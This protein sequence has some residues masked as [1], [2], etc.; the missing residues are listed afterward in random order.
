MSNFYLQLAERVLRGAI[1]PLGAQDII[2][3]ANERGLIP[4]KYRTAKTPDRTVQARIA[5]S[6][7]QLGAKSPFYR[8]APGRFGLREKLGDFTYSQ[9]FKREYKAPIRRKQISNEDI[10]CIPRKRLNIDGQNGFFPYEEFFSSI[11]GNE[12]LQYLPRKRLEHDSTYKQVVTYIAVVKSHMVLCY[13]RGLYAAVQDELIGRKSIG[14]GGHVSELDRDLFSIDDLGILSNGRRE[15]WEE[16]ALANQAEWDTRKLEITGL[17]NDNSTAEG[18]KHIAVAML[19][20]CEEEDDPIKGELEIRNLH[21]LSSMERPNDLFKFE[22]WSQIYLEQL[23]RTRM[24]A[25]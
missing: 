12:Y 1:Q 25:Y 23:C 18:Q 16:L 11:A 4:I 3:L 19:Y 9:T 7:R 6:I 20:S 14:F 2:R 24:R 15:L 8:Y 22:A 17:I 21:W 5:E 13:E 10:L